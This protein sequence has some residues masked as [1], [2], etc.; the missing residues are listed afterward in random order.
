MAMAARNFMAGSTPPTVEEMTR[1]TR[2]PRPLV[3]ESVDILIHHRLLQTTGTSPEKQ[4]VIP[5]RP[6][7][8]IS[9][10]D[11]IDAMRRAKGQNLESLSEHR[12]DQS[13]GADDEM[14]RTIQHIRELDQANC[15][16]ITL[17]ELI[18]TPAGAA[19]A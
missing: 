16:K 17:K 4:A 10:F 15:E 18:S 11:I 19:T 5:A 13:A 12:I 2:I 7:E 6:V 3:Q 9:C 1:I 8:T 14:I